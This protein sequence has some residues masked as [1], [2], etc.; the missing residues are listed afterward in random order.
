MVLEEVFVEAL[1]LFLGENSII[2]FQPIFFERGFIS[3]L[4]VSARHQ[5][6]GTEFRE[7]ISHPLPWIS[8]G[9]TI[10]YH[11]QLAGKI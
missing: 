2:G 9:C 10:S 8:E 1:V 5:D 7:R 11:G 6:E 3:E 4:A